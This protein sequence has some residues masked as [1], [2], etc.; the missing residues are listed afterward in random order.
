MK[1]NKQQT[2][3]QIGCAIKKE[4]NTVILRV[5]F[6]LNEFISVCF[7]ILNTMLPLLF[8]A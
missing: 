7:K 6:F 5:Q 8:G 2:I 4:N 3:T 1:N